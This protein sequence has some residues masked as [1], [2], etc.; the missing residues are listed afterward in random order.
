M[1]GIT[2]M[3]STTK[4]VKYVGLFTMIAGLILLLTGGIVWGVITSEL[5]ASGGQQHGRNTLVRYP[6]WLAQGGFNTV[7]HGR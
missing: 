7:R 4:P 2:R 3:S 5:A 6:G 1:K